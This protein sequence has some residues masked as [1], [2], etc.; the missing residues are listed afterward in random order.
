MPVHAVSFALMP[1]KARGRRELVPAA[2]GML[3]PIGLQ[4]RVD[5]FAKRFSIQTR[6]FFY[7]TNSLIVALQS[8]GTMSAPL[9]L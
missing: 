6:A 9:R 2:G 4:V 7:D 1:E 5:V 3:A 8:L